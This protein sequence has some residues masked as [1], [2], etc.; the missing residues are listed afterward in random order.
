MRYVTVSL[1]EI[2]IK[3][4]DEIIEK[5]I[6]G[7]VS[8]AE[9]IKSAIRRELSEIKKEHTILTSNDYIY[10]EKRRKYVRKDKLK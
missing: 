2:L 10:D 7:Y 5:R 9:F 8:R 3:E 1:P 6:K 4:I